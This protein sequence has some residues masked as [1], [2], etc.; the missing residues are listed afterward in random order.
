M[1]ETLHKKDLIQEKIQAGNQ[2]EN[3][4]LKRVQLQEESKERIKLKEEFRIQKTNYQKSRKDFLGIRKQLRSGNYSEKE[5]EITATY[6]NSSID[7]MISHLEKVKFNLE[8][9]KGIGTETRLGVIEDRIIQL[10]EEKEAIGNAENL[11]DFLNAA[12]SLRGVWNN[13]RNSA[14][15]ETGQAAG[16]KIDQFTGKSEA[17][18]KKLEKEIE[19]LNEIGVNTAGLESKLASC[20][21]LMDSARENNKA[22]KKIYNKE[23]PIHEELQKADDYLQSALKDIKE[24][25]EVLKEIFEELELYRAENASK[26]RTQSNPE[27]ELNNTGNESN[28]DD[29]S[30]VSVVSVNETEISSEVGTNN[31]SGNQPGNSSQD[32]LES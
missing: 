27:T 9:S 8:Q 24:A 29:N 31:S 25:N 7:Y 4:T 18:S 14:V 16:E 15:V 23:N 1:V 12:E 2:T 30:S 20:D 22:A 21:F 17:I 10:Q 13:V 32:N 19:S 11:E 26:T 28:E 6:L 3:G 5:L